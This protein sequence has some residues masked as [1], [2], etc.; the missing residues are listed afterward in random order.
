MDTVHSTTKIKKSAKVIEY[1]NGL[2]EELEKTKTLMA[3]ID[4]Q[5]AIHRAEI[6]ELRAAANENSESPQVITFKLQHIAV[7]LRLMR[8]KRDECMAKINNI[9]KEVADVLYLNE[10]LHSDVNPYEVVE[11]IT[12]N[13]WVVRELDATLKPEARKNIQESFCPGGFA[14]HVDND[15]QEWD[16]RVNENN[17]LITVY[18]GKKNKYFKIGSMPMSMTLSPIKIYDF[19]F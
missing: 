1:Q 9:E 17:P 12:P 18:R 15:Y 5:I 13:K 3:K 2:R 7:E 4:N 14:G 16:I 19:N 6:E 11:M 8:E 10:I